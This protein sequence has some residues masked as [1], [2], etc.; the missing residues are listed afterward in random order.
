MDTIVFAGIS[1]LLLIPVIYFIPL[2]LT[3]KGKIVIIAS[4]FL[5]A[6]VGLLGN[7]LYPIWLVGLLGIILLFFVTYFFGKNMNQFI[8]QTSNEGEE[9]NSNDPL[10]SPASSKKSRVIF[11]KDKKQDKDNN[12]SETNITLDDDYII[13][14]IDFNKETNVTKSSKGLEEAIQIPSV[15]VEKTDD[16]LEGQEENLT[17]IQPIIPKGSI[18]SDSKEI[19]KVELGE[20]MEQPHIAEGANLSEIEQLLEE[21]LEI[22]ELE[23]LQLNYGK[24]AVTEESSEVEKLEE[25]MDQSNMVEGT[26]LS[27]IEQ[28]LEEASEIEVLGEMQYY[29]REVAA[30]EELTMIEGLEEMDQSNIVEGTDLFEIEQ[31]LEEASEIVEPGE[32]QHDHGEVAATEESSD[33]EKLEEMGQSSIVDGTDLSE[34]AQVLEKDFGIKEQEE[35]QHNNIEMDESNVGIITDESD[36]K[37]NWVEELELDKSDFL[38]TEDNKSLTIDDSD[39]IDVQYLPGEGLQIEGSKKEESIE[40]AITL[41]PDLYKTMLMQIQLAKTEMDV[42]QYEG[43]VKGYLHPDLGDEEYCTFAFCLI[44]HYI[45]EKK[46]DDLQVFLLD[47]KKRFSH[48]PVLIQELDFIE[49]YYVSK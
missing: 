28:L 46:I 5:T 10:D 42:E 18:L 8:V 44:E 27:E 1:L 39:S 6:I 49:N 24:V 37:E 25:K 43:F 38:D 9:M 21:D 17:E 36:K 13:P 20:K 30:T 15:E 4:A 3:T 26:N 45:E 31:L 16:L 7:K 22:K 33:I 47:L 11:T 12:K 14:V 48:Y 23:N 32:V 2:S 19:E 41:Q 35:L 29:H 40:S 34:I